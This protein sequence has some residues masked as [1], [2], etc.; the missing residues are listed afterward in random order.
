[1]TQTA[2]H[3]RIDQRFADLK[4]SGK[5]GFIAYITAG[6]PHLKATEDIIYRLEDADEGVERFST[7]HVR[8]TVQRQH[9]VVAGFEAKISAYEEG[10]PHG[11]A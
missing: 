2:T 8:R 6:D 5:K 3:T 1:M 7:I 4:A 11:F 10:M 9:R